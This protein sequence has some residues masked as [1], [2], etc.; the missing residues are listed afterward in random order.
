VVG[1][2]ASHVAVRQPSELRIDD[3][4][5]LVEGELVSVA[6]GAEQLADVGY[7]HRARSLVP[8]IGNGWHSRARREQGGAASIPKCCVSVVVLNP[9]LGF[10]RILVHG[11]DRDRHNSFPA[12]GVVAFV[13]AEPTVGLAE[14][15]NFVRAA[16]R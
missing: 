13:A 8:A 11:F 10:E 14:I 12:V 1:A 15:A 2:L 16:L 4:R 9:L 7:R 3:R 5:Q 6:P